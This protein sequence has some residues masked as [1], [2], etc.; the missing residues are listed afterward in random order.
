MKAFRI[1]GEFLMGDTWQRFRLE[2]ASED[3]ES[4]VE[5]ML[6]DIGGRHGTKRKNIKVESVTKIKPDEVENPLV[7]EELEGEKSGK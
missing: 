4:A 5:Q 6:S 3:E 2:M 7:K 1:E